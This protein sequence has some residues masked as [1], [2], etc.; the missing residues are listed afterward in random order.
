MP[1]KTGKVHV[2]AT[3]VFDIGVA[4]AYLADQIRDAMAFNETPAPDS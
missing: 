3:T 2:Q 1:N 4:S